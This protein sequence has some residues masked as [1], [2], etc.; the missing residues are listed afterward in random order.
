MR[1]DIKATVTEE[2]GRSMEV[3]VYAQENYVSRKSGY[4]SIL[5]RVIMRELTYDFKSILPF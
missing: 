5:L 3:Q 4:S 1:S 2:P